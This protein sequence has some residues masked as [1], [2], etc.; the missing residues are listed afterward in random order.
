MRKYRRNYMKNSFLSAHKARTTSAHRV[1]GRSLKGI[2][3]VGIGAVSLFLL[4]VGCADDGNGAAGSSDNCKR[5]RDASA[6]YN[7]GVTNLQAY[8]SHNSIWVHWTATSDTQFGG[9]EIEL[10]QGENCARLK[11]VSASAGQD[12]STDVSATNGT[13]YRVDVYAVD[14]S[15]NRGTR[16]SVSAVTPGAGVVIDCGN[17][18]SGGAATNRN[19]NGGAP[20]LGINITNQN[21]TNTNTNNRTYCLDAG[22]SGQDATADLATDLAQLI[23]QAIALARQ[24][25][26][27]FASNPDQLASSVNVAQAR[28][29]RGSAGQPRFEFQNVNIA[30][31]FGSSGTRTVVFNEDPD[32][33]SD[34]S[35]TFNMGS[36]HFANSFG[37]G[38]AGTFNVIVNIGN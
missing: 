36:S 5:S 17:S 15:G 22:R 26:G 11:E 27:P 28:F 24:S 14:K 20:E 30:A 38:D 25:G 2:G 35:L 8:A 12:A 31:I 19:R 1:W 33:G 6:D 16:Q 4:M 7:G 32:T 37:A 18:A 13:T 23:V 21:N 10:Y 9:V 3:I 29:V 34:N